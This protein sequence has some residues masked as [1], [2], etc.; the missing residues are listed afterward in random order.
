MRIRFRIHRGSIAAPLPGSKGKLHLE[1][2]GSLVADQ[3]LYR[4]FLLSAEEAILTF[5]TTAFLFLLRRPATVLVLLPPL[6]DSLTSDIQI[7]S[8]GLL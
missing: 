6:D 7:I 1:L 4:R 2:I 3:L 5:P 8:H